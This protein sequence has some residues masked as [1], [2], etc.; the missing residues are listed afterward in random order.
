MAGITHK[1]IMGGEDNPAYDASSGEWNEPHEVSGDFDFVGAGSQPAAPAAGKV[2]QF[3]K[4]TG[5]SPN[6]NIVIGYLLEDG[7]PI[8]LADVTI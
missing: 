6:K 3:V 4:I 7:T 1:K 2:K 8:I 5:T